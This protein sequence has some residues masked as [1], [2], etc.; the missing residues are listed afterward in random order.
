MIRR[1]AVTQRVVDNASYPEPRDALAQ[2]WATWLATV[3]PEAALLAVPNRP[4]G[5]DVWWAAVRPEALVLSGGNDWGSAPARD[6]TETRLLAKARKEGLPVLAVC[7]GLQAVNVLFGG[8]LIRD[9]GTRTGAKHVAADHPVTLDGSAI[10]GM[11]SG[12]SLTVNSFHNQ[13]VGVDGVASGFSVFATAADGIVEGMAHQREPILAVQWHPE[14]ASPSAAFDTAIARALLTKGA[15][16]A[17]AA[18]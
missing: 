13:G 1:I 8:A 15:F 12:R 11:A 2:D 9:V 10:A 17:G 7:R 3:A 14:R 4:D 5:V 16:W 18:S 6:A